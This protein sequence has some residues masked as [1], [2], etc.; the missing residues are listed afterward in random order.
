MEGVTTA[1]EKFSNLDPA[2]ISRIEGVS[3]DD[4]LQLYSVRSFGHDIFISPGKR[5]LFSDS[6]E[7]IYLLGIK[8]Y[9]CDLSVLWYLI[10]Y[11]DIPLSGN[12]V[13]PANLPGGQI[14]VQGTHVLPL[15]EIAQRYNNRKKEFLDLGSRYGGIET[16]HGD[17]GVR[18]LPFPTVP[19]YLILWFGDESFPPKGQLLLDS[20]CSHYLSTD[21]IWAVTSIC[22][23]LFL[24]GR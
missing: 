11:R 20:S 15:D 5:E 10:S 12:L 4:T 3:Y 21:V 17:V 14:F 2:E 13:K 7:G 1:W 19:V 9:F 16:D 8:E 18:L 6:A 22:C 23:V 24:E